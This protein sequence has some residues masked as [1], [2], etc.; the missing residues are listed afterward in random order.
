M[1]V[2]ITGA[3]ANAGRA[4]T[5][6]INEYCETVGVDSDLYHY[7]FMETGKKYFNKKGEIKS[8][9]KII[10]K[11]KIDYVYCAPDIHIIKLSKHLDYFPRHASIFYNKSIVQ[12]ILR[13]NNIKS[14]N[15]FKV[16]NVYDLQEAFD[17]FGKVWLRANV[18]SAGKGAFCATDL[19]QAK[20]WL[21]INKQKKYEWVA[22]EYLGGKNI[23]VDL[24]IKD[25]GD[26]EYFIKERIRYFKDKST[27]VTEVA[28]CIESKWLKNIALKSVK[29]VWNEARGIFSVDFKY[30]NNIPYVTEINAGR[31]L[32]SS[33]MFFHL[34]NYNLPANYLFDK[35]LGKYPKGKKLVRSWDCYPKI[36]K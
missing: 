16:K 10:K 19:K 36:I 25:N 35:K 9:L 4:F 15:F 2:L 31:F 28:K 34:T 14:P 17:R 27:G 21:E 3:G 6:C 32:S 7:N 20:S 30:K 24:V 22:N 33:L 12:S 18:G 5:R 13:D 8:I 29:S 11:E 1:K 26:V 23:G